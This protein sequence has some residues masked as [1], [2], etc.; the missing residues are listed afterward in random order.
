MAKEDYKLNQSGPEVQGLLNKIAALPNAAELTAL[1]ALKQ[2]LLTF[3]DTPTEG[4]SNP[5]TSDGIHQALKALESEAYERVDTYADLGDASQAK[6]GKIWLVGLEGAD[7]FDRYVAGKSGNN[8]VW[9]RSVRP[10]FP[11]TSTTPN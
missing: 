4:S 10:R 5:V 9:C 2:N 7:S 6:M 8:Y 1:L 11:S 3:D